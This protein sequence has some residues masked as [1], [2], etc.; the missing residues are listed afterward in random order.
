ML[1]ETVEEQLQR[2]AKYPNSV[3]VKKKRWI[4]MKKERKKRVF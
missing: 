1:G 4:D 3:S 2:E